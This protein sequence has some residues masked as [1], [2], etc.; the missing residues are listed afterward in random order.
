MPPCKA[1]LLSKIQRTHYLAQ[2]VKSASQKYIVRR[3]EEGWIINEENQMLIEYFHGEPYPPIIANMA[4]NE[5][6]E[7]DE[8]IVYDSSTDD[9]YISDEE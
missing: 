8:S 4:M 1:V 5:R 6:D 7:D 3:T 9:E 2:M